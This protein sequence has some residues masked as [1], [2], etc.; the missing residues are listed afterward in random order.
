MREHLR[1]TT[2][3]AGF[4]ACRWLWGICDQYF[5]ET[6]VAVAGIAAV[7]EEVFAEPFEEPRREIKK[8]KLRPRRTLWCLLSVQT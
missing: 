2:I 3:P 6:A 5:A 1:T 7:A 4:A 8:E